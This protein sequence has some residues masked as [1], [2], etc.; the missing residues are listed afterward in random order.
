[1]VLGFSIALILK[2]FNL[3]NVSTDAYNNVVGY[4]NRAAG[5]SLAES[6]ANMGSQVIYRVPNAFPKWTNVSLSGGKVSLKTSVYDTTGRIIL[7]STSNYQN[8]LDTVII[9]WGQSQ[10][11]KFAYYSGVE[12]S[13]NWASKD[14]V[15]GPFH[16]QDKMTINGSPVFWGKV[17]NKLGMTS[18]QH[19]VFN[20]GYQ[21]GIDIPMPSDF[22]PLKNAA[23]SGGKVP[24][25][26]RRDNNV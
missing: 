4:Y 11:S 25:W 6:F 21:T 24:P 1:M 26:A 5:H 12:G 9:I 13:I 20:A 17:T 19:P 7:V 14:T 2:G 10:F 3:S 15:Y 23:L 16:T 8:Y 18:G 22:T